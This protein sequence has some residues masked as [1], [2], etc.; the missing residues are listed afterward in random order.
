VKFTT[1]TVAQLAPPPGSGDALFWDEAIP[2]FGIRARASGRKLW[3]FQYRIGSQQRRMT[4]GLVSAIGLGEARKLA[5]QLYAKTKLGLDPAGDKLE[6]QAR[7]AETF[8]AAAELFLARQKIRLR[9]QAYA[10]V[11]RHLLVNAKPLHRLPLAKVDRRAIAALL[12]KTAT[13]VSGAS[14]NRL[15]TTLSS[16]FAWGIRD[17]LI[18]N[19]PVV[20]TEARDEKSR[21]R[22]LTDSEVA[23]IWTALQDDAYGAI[24]RLLILT[25]ARRAEIGVLRW[26]E[27]DLEQGLITLPGERTKNGRPHVIVLSQPAIEVL[28]TRPSDREFVLGRGWNGFHSWANSKNALD[29]RILEACKAR[30]VGVDV[31]PMPAWTLH[32]FRRYLSTTMHERLGIPPHIVESVLGHIGHQAGVA[33][34]YNKSLYIAEKAQAMARW[35]EHVMSIVEGRT[36]KVVPL[37]A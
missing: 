13:A 28:R 21:D 6:H 33:G 18:E 8:E 37:H 5:T 1:Q 14:T 27:V 31:V 24:V 23:E 17:G 15:R 3:V 19:N 22:M 30:A 2:G 4:L 7:T 25:G 26:S 32:D 11:A 16:F 34:R 9:P 36:S 12:T 10:P 29:Q 20:G 35:A